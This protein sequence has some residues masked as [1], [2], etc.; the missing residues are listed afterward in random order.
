MAKSLNYTYYTVYIPHPAIVI[1]ILYLY[2]LYTFT[3]PSHIHHTPMYNLFSA[4]YV[5]MCAHVRDCL[6]SVLMVKHTQDGS[7]TITIARQEHL[8]LKAD[9]LKLLFTGYKDPFVVYLFNI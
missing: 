1:Y 4:S 2:I 3:H 9:K 6:C 5:Y 8:F 7:K